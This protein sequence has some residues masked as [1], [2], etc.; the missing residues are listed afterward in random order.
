MGSTTRVILTVALCAGILIA[1]QFLFT[2]KQAPPR[3]PGTGSGAVASQPTSQPTNEPA[4]SEP[5][6]RPTSEPASRPTSQPASQPTSQP[7]AGPR[8]ASA[9]GKHLTLRGVGGA[10]TFTTRGGAL[11]RWVLSDPRYKEIKNGKLRPVDL[12]HTDVR[13]GSWPLLTTFPQSDFKVPTD[14]E[15]KVAQKSDSQVRYVWQS[16]R[17]RITKH[18]T[19][20]PVRPVVWLTV[21]VAN[22]TAGKLRS[23]LEVSLYSQQTGQGT[24]SFTNPYP[25]VSTVL[26]YINGKLHR[27]SADAIAGKGGGCSSFGSSLGCGMEQGGVTQTGDVLWLGSDD[28]YFLTALVPLEKNEERRCDLKLLENNLIQ[29]SLLYPEAGIEPGKAAR[30]TFSIFVGPKDL[31][32][33]DAVKGPDGRDVRLSEAIEFGWFAVLCRPMLW[34]MKIFHSWFHNWGIAIILLTIV[35]KLLTLYWTQKSMRSM[36][37]MTRLKPKIDALRDKYKDDKQ[38]LNQEMMSLYKLHKVNPLGGCL[39]ILIQM[40]IW[41][42]LYRTLGNAVELYRSHFVGWITDLTAPDPYYVLPIAMG[43]SMYAQQAITPQPMEGT[44][45]KVMKYFMPGMFTVMMLA[46]PS[47]LTLYIFVN[48]VLTMIHQWYMNKKDPPVQPSADKDLSR[49]RAGG[50]ESG[51]KG[52][53]R[54]RAKGRS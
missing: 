19:I 28:R 8:A 41:F 21:E 10:G 9:E 46:L 49:G 48:T 44:Q 52:K 20:D 50:Q 3:R 1:W 29:A 27:R 25:P 4:E 40:P 6:S 16:A 53:Q 32:G 11:R 35:V 2:S 7:A 54:R 31:K 37:E 17:V 13:R 34:L 5:A 51:A 33:M 24:A 15:F 42:A 39:P 22:L 23:H 45:A 26:C 43:I 30:H 12:V 14:A 47:G 38:R 36:K 18:Y